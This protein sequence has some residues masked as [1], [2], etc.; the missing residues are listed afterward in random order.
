MRK[1][2]V[3]V[4]EYEN[5]LDAQIARG[6]LEASGVS[7]SIIKDDGGGML[8]ALQN[9]EGVQLIVAENQKEKAMKIL[10]TKPL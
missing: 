2:Q 3:V 8:P 5:E 1:K 6:H 10:Q 4:G 9:S 7:A